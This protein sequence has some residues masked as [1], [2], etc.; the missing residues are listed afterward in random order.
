MNNRPEKSV[1]ACVYVKMLYKMNFSVADVIKVFVESVWWC[2][3][4]S[5]ALPKSLKQSYLLSYWDAC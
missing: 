2:H 1:C 3:I 5:Y 4:W